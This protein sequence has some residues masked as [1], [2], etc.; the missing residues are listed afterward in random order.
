MIPIVG[1]A[2]AVLTFYG[3]EAWLRKTPWLFTD[4]LEWTQISRAIEETGH[5]ARR[6]DPIFFK[7]LYAFLIAPFWAIH[8]TETAYAAIKYMN[9]VVMTLAAVPTYLLARMMLSKRASLVVALLAVCIPG[10]AYVTTI[11]PEVARLPVVRAVLLADRARARD[12]AAARLSSGSRV[13]CRRRAAGPL[14][15]VRDGARVVPDRRRRSS[16]SP[17]PRGQALRRD[18][19]PRR[20]HRRR[21]RCSPAR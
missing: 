7:S 13:A 19:T 5:A 2:L 12:A 1:I 9:A 18:G 17:A 16:G 15:A 20:Q 8:S 21:R 10:M 3:V 6:G 11:V 14:A 4:E